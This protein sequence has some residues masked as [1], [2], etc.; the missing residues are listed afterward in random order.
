MLRQAMW[1]ER[2]PDAL[3]DRFSNPTHLA[4]APPFDHTDHCIN[5]LRETI[6]CHADTV[7]VVWQWSDKVQAATP[8][9]DVAHTCKD[10]RK[11]HSWAQKMRSTIHFDGKVHIVDDLVFPDDK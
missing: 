2:Y 8:R 6:M 7:P 9:F 1:P 11:I 5:S 3:K 4:N 10:Y